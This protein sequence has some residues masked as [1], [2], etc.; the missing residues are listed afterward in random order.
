MFPTQTVV[1]EA[2]LARLIRRGGLILL[3]EDLDAAWS[4]LVLEMNYD[5]IARYKL[6]G[7]KKHRLGSCT[8]RRC[9]YCLRQEPATCFKKIAHA[10]PECLG[11]RTLISHDECDHCNDR[12][13]QTI[14]DH[15]DKFTQPLRTV[16]GIK[17]RNGVPVFKSRDG[18]SRVELNDISPSWIRRGRAS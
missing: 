12:F 2:A 6:A 9:R 8:P 4:D 14:E 5:L 7:G 17:G 15:L 16:L 18:K 11:N 1:E 3:K 13:S 10:I